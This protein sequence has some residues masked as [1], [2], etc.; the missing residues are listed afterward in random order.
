MAQKQKDARAFVY[1]VI[2]IAYTHLSMFMAHYYTNKVEVRLENPTFADKILLEPLKRVG[3][4]L[5]GT[6][7]KG[8]EDVD[9]TAPARRQLFFAAF[10]IWPIFLVCALLYWLAIV[11]MTLIVFVALVVGILLSYILKMFVFVLT[12]HRIF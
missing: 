1:L 8:K 3:D 6:K 7:E 5:P 12:S 10:F 11:L 2:F 4:T 9:L